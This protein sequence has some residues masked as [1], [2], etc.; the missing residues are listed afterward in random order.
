MSHVTIAKNEFWI[1]GAPTYTGRTFEGKPVQGLLFNVRAV[2]ATFDDANPNTRQHW[3]YPDTGVWDPDRNTDELC[4]ALPAW[5]DQGV[6]ALTVNFQG[7]GAIY[8]PEVYDH[9]D[10]N[11]FT[12]AGELKPAYADR[13][14]R[15]LSHADE[16]GM[17][18]IV[19]LFYWKH[20]QKLADEA[21]VWHAA[22]NALDFLAATA[23]RNILVEIANETD[24][25]GFGHAILLPE[26]A[27]HMIDALRQ[28]HPQFLYSTSQ[29]GAN[30]ETGR[31]IPPPSLVEA[32]DYVFL[33]G[34]GCDPARL[35][36]AI[37][38]VQAIPAFQR[39]PK[40]LII[41]EDSPGLP[42]LEVAWRNDV[43]WGYYDQG[44]GSDWKGDRWVPYHTQEREQ[45]YSSLS[46]FQTP[47]VNWGIN[48]EHKRAFFGR[49][50]EITG[51][52]GER[53]D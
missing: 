23:H 14:G 3:I 11:G 22:T 35:E 49:V 34:N 52:V 33:H 39:N 48:T 31:G 19:G 38:M 8:R 26:E 15:V 1:D 7:G 46:G 50:A 30:P 28:R 10:N 16:L 40:P 6:L 17:V 9:Y 21:A 24:I 41:N 44:F 37:H 29:V 5:R 4:A 2:Q 36:Q 51:K 20:V 32:V 45:E 25:S 27:H 18:V 12:P 13:M 47:P 43:S 53:G 42:N